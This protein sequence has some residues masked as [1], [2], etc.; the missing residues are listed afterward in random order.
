MD[1]CKAEMKE[2]SE[3][4]QVSN[5]LNEGRPFKLVCSQ[6]GNRTLMQKNSNHNFTIR[7]RGNLDNSHLR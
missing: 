1:E 2:F 3:G 6:Q 5:V 4:P 7:H